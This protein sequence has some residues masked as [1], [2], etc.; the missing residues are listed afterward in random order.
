MKSQKL[1]NIHLSNYKGLRN[2]TEFQYL[3]DLPLF[4]GLRYSI[5]LLN[6]YSEL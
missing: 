3:L 1:K 2:L 6:F 4:Y 5:I